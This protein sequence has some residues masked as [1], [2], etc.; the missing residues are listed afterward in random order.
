MDS[1]NFL[2]GSVQGDI[3]AQSTQNILNYHRTFTAAQRDNNG[4]V[5][6]VDISD[7]GKR[8]ALEFR[9]ALGMDASGKINVNRCEGDAETMEAIQDE[10]E[11][12]TE[13]LSEIAGRQP[14][15]EKMKQAAAEIKQ[16]IHDLK[17]Q[18]KKSASM[19]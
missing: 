4:R 11:S 9:E 18:G 14:Q 19:P 16:R 12:L 2:N 17:K 15:T 13:Q 8:L 1:V 6:T 7:E 3:R 10:L 5:D